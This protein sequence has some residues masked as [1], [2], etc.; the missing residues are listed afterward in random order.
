[1]FFNEGNEGVEVD[2]PYFGGAGPR[3]AGCIH[4]S[5]CF[6]GCKHNAK[7]TTT[8]NYLYLAEENGAEVHPLTTVTSVRAGRRRAGTSSRP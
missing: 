6:T 1:M 7:N 8:T 3:R 5:E 4:C 2:D